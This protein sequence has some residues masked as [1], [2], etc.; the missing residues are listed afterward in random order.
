MTIA[1]PRAR[2]GRGRRAPH[3]TTGN[4]LA[5]RHRSLALGPAR[6][7]RR[8]CLVVGVSGAAERDNER[9]LPEA[10]ARSSPSAPPPR[11]LQTPAA[12]GGAIVQVP[13]LQSDGPAHAAPEPPHVAC[14]WPNI[15]GGG[16]QAIGAA[17]EALPPGPPK[18]P[19]QEAPRPPHVPSAQLKSTQSKSLLQDVPGP[20]PAHVDPTIPAEHTP[21]TH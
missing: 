2:V 19:A 7:L 9:A 8:L 16:E 18:P 17:H 14:G 4:R 21:E 1:W 6:G 13:E 12:A 3:R 15:M 10:A 5:A 20:V 11:Y